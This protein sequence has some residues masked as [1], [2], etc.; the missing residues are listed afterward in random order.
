MSSSRREFAKRLAVA[1]VAVPLLETVPAAAQP[2]AS[3]AQAPPEPPPGSQNI[4]IG[5][6]QASVL[7]AR[8]GQHLTPAD[9]RKIEDDLQGF[10][11]YLKKLHEHELHNWDEP[12]T[13][14]FATGRDE[15]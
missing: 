9:A 4:R 11:G 10:D 2:S 1:A 13:L 15:A 5:E 8:Y 3:P 6:A 7:R 12:D 14:F